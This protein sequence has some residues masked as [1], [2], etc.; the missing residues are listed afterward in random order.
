ML[1][2]WFLYTSQGIFLSSHTQ[3]RCD[4]AEVRAMGNARAALEVHRYAPARVRCCVDVANH[5][6]NRYIEGFAFGW[7]GRL[8]T[9]AFRVAGFHLREAA[10]A[11]S[12]HAILCGVGGS[13]DVGCHRRSRQSKLDPSSHA[14]GALHCDAL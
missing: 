3:T 5:L 1:I 13:R 9:T 8:T 10:A 4:R 12:W 7:V 14:H 11:G 6:G 2:P